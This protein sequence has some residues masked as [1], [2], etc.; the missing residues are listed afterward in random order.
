[1]PKWR[2]HGRDEELKRLE[3]HPE[4]SDVPGWERSFRAFGRVGRR[5]TGKRELSRETAKRSNAKL[6][7]ISFECE[8]SEDVRLLKDHPGKAQQG[9]EGRAAAAI[10]RSLRCPSSAKLPFSCRRAR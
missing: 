6:A 9:C 1:M 10:P 4:L 3:E 5:E 2:F 7:I 8:H